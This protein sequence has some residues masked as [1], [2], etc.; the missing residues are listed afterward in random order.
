M[1]LELNIWWSVSLFA[2]RIVRVL[3]MPILSGH[4]VM[5][6]SIICPC[7]QRGCVQVVLCASFCLNMVLVTIR[8]NSVHSANRSSQLELHFPILYLRKTGGHLSLFSSYPCIAVSYQQELVGTG[9]VSECTLY[10]TV[11][12]LL[13]PVGILHCWSICTD[14]CSIPVLCERDSHSHNPVTHWMWNFCQLCHD[15]P[16][17]CKSNSSFSPLTVWLVT[18]IE[19]ILQM[20]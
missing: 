14:Y 18:P 2:P 20:V 13:V 6:K 17:Y 16:F 8:S 19:G 1:T 7:R 3:Q 10:L 12:W 4:L 15:V 11:K 9:D 5:M